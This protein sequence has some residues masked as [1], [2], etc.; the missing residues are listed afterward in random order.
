MNDI[1]YL[2]WAIAPACM[3]AAAVLPVLATVV[4]LLMDWGRPRVR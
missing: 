4:G 1:E 2:F 3:I